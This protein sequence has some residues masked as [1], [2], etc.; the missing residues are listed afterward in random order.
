MC[1]D[2]REPNKAI[3]VDSQ[4]LP[5]MDE[6]LA[7]LAGSILFS[8]IDLESAYH[9]LPL[10]PDSRDL[11]AFITHEGLF[12]FCRVPYG[13]ASAPAAF[14]KMMS[15]V[16][17]GVPNVQNYLDDIICFGSAQLLPDAALQEVLQR[18]KKAVLHINE[19]KCPACAFWDT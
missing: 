6:L 13:L 7:T 3:V 10:H 14:Q 18:L 11:T 15:V 1:V 4:P 12:R 5:H 19:K 8:T 17:Q 2:L 9:Q 16:L